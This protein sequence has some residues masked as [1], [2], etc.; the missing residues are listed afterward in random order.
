MPKPRSK[1]LKVNLSGVE[2][3]GGGGPV[4]DGRYVVKVDSASVEEGEKGPYVAWQ[5]KIVGPTCEGRRLYDNTSFSVN[6]LWRLRG[7]LEAMEEEIPDEEFDFDPKDY[8]GKEFGVEIVNETYEGKQK[9]RVAEYCL[10][11]DV[12]ESEGGGDEEP[13]PRSKSKIKEGSKVTFKDDDGK[14][15]KGTVTSI[16]GD[17]AEVDV[18]GEAWDIKVDELSLA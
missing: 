14:T 18:N 4:P 9:P 12:G 11:A 8:Y 2:Y 17:D 5:F 6:A 13:A 1:G 16:D 15:K 7:L 3:K 10:A